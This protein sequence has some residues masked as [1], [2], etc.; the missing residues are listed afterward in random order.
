MWYKMWYLPSNFKVHSPTE[1]S[2]C[3]EPFKKSPPENKVRTPTCMYN[4]SMRYINHSLGWWPF[5]CQANGVGWF[6]TWNPSASPQLTT[7]VKIVWERSLGWHDISDK[8]LMVK[9]CL[10]KTIYFHHRIVSARLVS[11]R[12]K[13][14]FKMIINIWEIFQ[15]WQK[16]SDNVGISKSSPWCHWHCIEREL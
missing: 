10:R 13:L 8:R 3:H 14:E 9:C 11:V 6:P 5:C 15:L 12:V 4:M 16:P 1:G 2:S 7:Q